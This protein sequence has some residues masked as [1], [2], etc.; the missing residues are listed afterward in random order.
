MIPWFFA[1]D[2]INYAGYLLAYYAQ[3]TQLKETCPDVYGHVQ[4][5]GFTDT[6]N[7][8]AAEQMYIQGG[9]FRH[10]DLGKSWI[11]R[12]ELDVASLVDLFQNNW[13]DPFGHDPSDLVSISTG[14]AAASDVCADLLTAKQK[15][16]NAYKNFQK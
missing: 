12:D 6:N 7:L 1:M 14:T 4:S 15:G 10:P 5:G 13:T 16:E 8:M 9:V 11:K 2:K 3:M